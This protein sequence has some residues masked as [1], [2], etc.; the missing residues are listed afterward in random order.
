[1][2]LRLDT[3]VADTTVMGSRWAPD[4]AAFAILGRNLHGSVAAN[5]RY[6]HSPFCGRWAK[7]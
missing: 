3:V 6:N 7:T 4:V 2:V 5:S 1:V